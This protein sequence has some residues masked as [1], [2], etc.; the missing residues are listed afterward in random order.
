MSC[1]GMF[2]CGVMAWSCKLD[3]SVTYLEAKNLSNTS[4]LSLAIPLEK[5][6]SSGRVCMALCQVSTRQQPLSA[7]DGLYCSNPGRAGSRFSRVF[8][9]SECQATKSLSH[10]V[11][12]A[13]HAF[14]QT[15]I[16]E[17]HSHMAPRQEVLQ[18][19][20][21]FNLAKLQKTLF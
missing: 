14:G 18:N 1:Q 12:R 21:F 4:S 19:T 16:F 9:N 13:L 15:C 10:A 20:E 8:H 11:F 7:V 5:V 2:H 3:D 6:P 17:T